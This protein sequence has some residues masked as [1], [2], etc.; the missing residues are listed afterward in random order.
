MPYGP[1]SLS[2]LVFPRA[3]AGR[4][5]R[6]DRIHEQ[7]AEGALVFLVL[8]ELG[9]GRAHGLGAILDTLAELAVGQDVELVVQYPLEH[10]L[11]D[12]F[13]GAE[14]MKEVAGLL[15]A[16]VGRGIASIGEWSGA[17]SSRLRRRG[18]RPSRGN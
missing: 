8:G 15:A 4:L 3:L 14:Q 9:H 10:P 2:C 1:R 11:A 16:L 7:K 17:G 12:L 13:L 5:G 18:S 6:V